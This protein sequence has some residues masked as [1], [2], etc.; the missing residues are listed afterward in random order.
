MVVDT[1]L[2]SPDVDK[3]SHSSHRRRSHSSKRRGT[4]ADHGASKPR[5]DDAISQWSAKS[6]AT[7]STKSVATAI[8]LDDSDESSRYV[9]M[10]ADNIIDSPIHLLDQRSRSRSRPQTTINLISAPP[11]PASQSTYDTR[12]SSSKSSKKSSK[13]SRRCR[14]A[15]IRLAREYK[16]SSD[17]QE[18]GHG[19]SAKV[20]EGVQRSTG[21]RVAIKTIDKSLVRRKDRIKREVSL[22]SKVHHPN[23]IKMYTNYEDDKEVHI[24]TDLCGGGELFDRIV[25]KATR[26]KERREKASDASNGGNNGS[27]DSCSTNNYLPACYDEIEAAKIVRSLL[28]ALSYLHSRGIVHRDVK[29]ENILFVHPEEEGSSNDEVKLVDFG[30]S[31]KHLPSEKPMTNAVGTS[32]YMAPEVLGGEYDRACDLWSL[33]VVAY[34]MLSGRPPFNGPDDEV[35]FKKVKRGRASMDDPVLWGGVSDVAKDFLRRLLDVDP[36]RRWTADMALCH[37]WMVAARE[38]E[39]C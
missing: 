28:S 39:R 21:R 32:Y 27:N 16:L 33:G 38:V 3:T 26:G 4:G 19:V 34:M 30:L 31:A 14:S 22:L 18:L 1:S 11:S 20:R 35:I 37:P 13:S 6:V 25:D 7:Q 17:K 9:P 29:P 12:S 23:I 15:R 2:I 8:T 24:V 10:I 36:G 5:L